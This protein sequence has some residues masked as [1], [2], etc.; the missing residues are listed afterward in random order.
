MHGR[1][2]RHVM[3]GRHGRHGRHARGR[4]WPQWRGRAARRRTAASAPPATARSPTPPPPGA[5]AR[6]TSAPC[7]GTRP[8][9]RGGCRGREAAVISASIF[10]TAAAPGAAIAWHTAPGSASHFNYFHLQSWRNVNNQCWI[11]SCWDS[12][13]R[14]LIFII[15]LIFVHSAIK[16]GPGPRLNIIRNK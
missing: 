9:C 16:C 11:A 15:K 7:P 10:R 8:R 14:G 1:H 6:R 13:Y 12:D 4:S 2:G 5:R 3:R